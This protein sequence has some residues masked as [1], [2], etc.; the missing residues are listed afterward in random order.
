MSFDLRLKHSS[1]G[2]EAGRCLRLSGVAAFIAQTDAVSSLTRKRA[3]PLNVRLIRARLA[4]V[5]VF[6]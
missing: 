5:F 1:V 2:W 4:G 3:V 6:Q